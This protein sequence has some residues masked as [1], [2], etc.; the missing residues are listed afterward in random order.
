MNS[1]R[2]TPRSRATNAYDLLND[3]ARAVLE[4][5]KRLN[6]DHW[7]IVGKKTIKKMHVKEPMC[8]TVGC[9]AG[10]VTVLTRTP[11]IERAGCQPSK[12]RVSESA[13]QILAGEVPEGGGFVTPDD[14]F[15]N[16]LENLF[17]CFPYQRAS[18]TRAYAREVVKALR[19]FQ[20][21]HKSRLKRTKV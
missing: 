1:F 11:T 17:H 16:D 5:P 19:A 10:W 4:E 3:V 7:L 12:R 13:I 8:N 9:L 20:K 2:L 18:G 15:V 14:K 21:K 6:M